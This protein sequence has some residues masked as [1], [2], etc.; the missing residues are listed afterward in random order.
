MPYWIKNPTKTNT[1]NYGFIRW[2]SLKIN[3]DSASVFMSYTIIG[4]SNPLV[5]SQNSWTLCCTFVHKYLES[6]NRYSVGHG[7]LINWES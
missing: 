4:S 1:E 5:A 7:I 6:R 3:C 2:C